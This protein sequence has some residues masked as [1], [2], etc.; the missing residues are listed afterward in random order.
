MDG[1]DASDL[2]RLFGNAAAARADD[3]RVD[4]AQLRRGGDNGQRRVFHVTVVMFYEY[5][6][7]H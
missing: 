4:F 5:K 2:G 1:G 6:S 7:F 3:Q